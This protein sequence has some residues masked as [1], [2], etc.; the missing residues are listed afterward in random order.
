MRKFYQTRPYWLFVLMCVG[1]SATGYVA[2]GI[3]YA[4][5]AVVFLA[6]CIGAGGIDVY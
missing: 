2:V 1:L 4:P 5:F 3:A 6:L